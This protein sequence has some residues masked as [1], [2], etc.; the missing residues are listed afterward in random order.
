MRHTTESRPKIAIIAEFPIGVLE[1]AM[2]GRGGGQAA[3][4]LPIPNVRLQLSII[5][6]DAIHTH[7]LSTKSLFIDPL[8]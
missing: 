5:L 7:A 1:G 8:I 4:W 6:P 3:T 2:A